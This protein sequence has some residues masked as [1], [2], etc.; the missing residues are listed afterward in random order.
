M[1][2]SVCLLEGYQL[3]HKLI[4][5]SSFN[6]DELTVVWQTINVEHECHCCVPAHTGIAHMMKVGVAL[7]EALRNR[8]AMPTKKLQVL[9]DTA[10]LMVRNRGQLNNAETAA[11][12]EVGYGHANYWKSYW[13]RRKK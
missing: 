5:D 12:Y 6:K 13:A 2:M 8:T 9:H 10:L 3:L 11:F 7:T 4:Q 1:A